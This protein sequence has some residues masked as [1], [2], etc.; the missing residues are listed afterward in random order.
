M[1]PLSPAVAPTIIIYGMRICGPK[2]TMSM[3]IIGLSNNAV[4][5][6]FSDKMK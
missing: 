6:S 5:G 4:V 3:L 2:N 1:D